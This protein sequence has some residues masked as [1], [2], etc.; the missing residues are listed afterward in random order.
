MFL[1]DPVREGQVRFNSQCRTSPVGSPQVRPPRLTNCRRSGPRPERGP[2]SSM[3]TVTHSSPRRVCRLTCSSSPENPD[4][5]ELVGIG[6]QDPLPSGQKGPR[7][8][9]CTRPRGA[10]GNPRDRQVQ[11]HR[12]LQRQ[13]QRPARELRP[14]PG[15]LARVLAPHCGRT[16]N[17]APRTPLTRHNPYGSTTRQSLHPRKA[18][19]PPNP[20][21]PTD[22]PNRLMPS[23]VKVPT[24]PQVGPRPETRATVS[25]YS[26]I[27]TSTSARD[28]EA[29]PRLKAARVPDR[30]GF[31]DLRRALGD[32][33]S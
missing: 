20:Y 9:R 7:C 23:S 33:A 22:A 13:A 31:P 19:T 5:V 29:F 8:W 1:L 4:T 27:H 17:D 32:S 15:G 26:A 24:P 3:V 18:P 12:G 6:E 28:C 30:L 10:I 2:V 14:W 25:P 11:H 21:R 16:G